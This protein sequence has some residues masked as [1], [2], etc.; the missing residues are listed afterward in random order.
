[1]RSPPFP[2]W[3][4]DHGCIVTIDAMGCQREIAQQITDG[5]ADYVLAVKTVN[6]TRA[7]ETSRGRKHWALTPYDYSQTVNHG[8]FRSA[9]RRCGFHPGFGLIRNAT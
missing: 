9:G 1:M 7:S 5:G 2:T 6:S 4:L 8:R 3:T